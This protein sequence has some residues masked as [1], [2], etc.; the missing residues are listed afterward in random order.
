[1]HSRDHHHHHHP[2][3]LPLVLVTGF[4]YVCNCQFLGKWGSL[5]SLL[6]QNV[7][8]FIIFS[9]RKELLSCLLICNFKSPLTFEWLWSSIQSEN[10]CSPSLH[11][12]SPSPPCLA[13]LLSVSTYL[14]TFGYSLSVFPFSPFFPSSVLNLSFPHSL[15]FNVNPSVHSQL[16]SCA[17]SLPLCFFFVSHFLIF[18]F[19]SVS[20]SLNRSCLIFHCFTVD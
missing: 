20:P 5:I 4:Q 1:M 14:F 8:W 19:Y 15:L 17:P 10:F 11:L 13:P 2:D 12:F 6:G 3:W 18:P 9:L 16:Y 7:H